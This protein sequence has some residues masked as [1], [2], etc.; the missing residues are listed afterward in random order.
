M[1]GKGIEQAPGLQ[2][3]FNPNSN[4]ADS[5]RNRNQERLKEKNKVNN[6][7]SDNVT[8]NKADILKQNGVPGGGIDKAPGLQKQ[9]KPKSNASNGNH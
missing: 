5:T 6:G 4:A 2:K 8:Q 7:Q 3:P 9:S 1:P